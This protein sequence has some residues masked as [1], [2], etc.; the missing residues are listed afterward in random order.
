[1]TTPVGPARA[2]RRGSLSPTLRGR[3]DK[4]RAHTYTFTEQQA[5]LNA[6]VQTLRLKPVIPVVHDASGPAGI[7][8]SLSHSTQV[9]ALVLLNTFYSAMPTTNPPEAI[10]LYS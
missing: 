5:E 1:M 10:R 7:N 6:V 3:S 9:A 2:A 4:P 8:W